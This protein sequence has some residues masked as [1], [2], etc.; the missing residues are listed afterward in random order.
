[1]K[2]D[3]VAGSKNDEFYTPQYAIDPI[4]KYLLPPPAGFGA[5]LIPKNRCM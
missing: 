2:L 5:R 1:M 3:V 4:M